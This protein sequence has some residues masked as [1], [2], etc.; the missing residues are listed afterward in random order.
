MN[1]NAI[2]LISENYANE[3]KWLLSNLLC[4]IQIQTQTCGV[5]TQMPSA[6]NWYKGPRKHVVTDINNGDHCASLHV[7]M[8]GGLDSRSQKQSS[9]PSNAME[10][11]RLEISC[12]YEFEL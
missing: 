9:K 10:I 11:S 2:V 5:R 3:G 12:V 1:E 6:P 4:V 8:L 7:D